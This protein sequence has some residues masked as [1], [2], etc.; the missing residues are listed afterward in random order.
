[1]LNDRST[2]AAPVIK[3]LCAWNSQK[4]LFPSILSVQKVFVGDVKT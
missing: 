4:P 2:A 1:L 3:N